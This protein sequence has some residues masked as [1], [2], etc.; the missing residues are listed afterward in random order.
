MNSSFEK[1]TPED[2]IKPDDLVK[3]AKQRVEELEKADQKAGKEAMVKILE[4]HMNLLMDVRQKYPLEEQEGREL[5]SSNIVQAKDVPQQVRQDLAKLH[6][7][8]Q[9]VIETVASKIE[10]RKYKSCQEAIQKMGLTP[11]E[12]HKVDKLV[13]ADQNLNLSCQSLKIATEYFKEVNCY[14]IDEINKAEKSQD[15]SQE[16]KLVI[17]NAVMVYEMTDFIIKYL[18]SFQLKGKDEILQLQGEMSKKIDNLRQQTQELKKQ[19][20]EPD[21]LDSFRKNTLLSIEA[22]KKAIQKI[23]EEWQH[24]LEKIQAQESSVNSLT[25]V[26]PSLKLHKA[27]AQQ[28][29]YLLEIMTIIN[30]LNSSLNALDSTI[31]TLEGMELVSIDEGRVGRLLGLS[32]L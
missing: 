5:L 7:T 10:E 3:I 31:K 12:L 22:R 29:L 2:S 14:I 23:E 9:M 4:E 1:T 24:Y 28:Q 16:R 26:L 6:S 15:K 17:A 8:M 18:E 20:E 30:I 21:I 13:K 25:K 19:A 11:N 32:T 27:N